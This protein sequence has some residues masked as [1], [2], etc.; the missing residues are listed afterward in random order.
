PFPEMG[1]EGAALATG[2]GQALSLV[3]YLA[4]Y[5]AKM[6]PIRLHFNREIADPA[7][8]KKMYAVGVPATFSLALPTLLITCLNIILAASSEVSGL[9]RGV[10]YKLQT[11]LY[12]PANGIVQGVR[13]L[14]GYNYGAKEP[15]RVRQIFL[16]G[17][18]LS[19]GIMVL[20][21]VLCW[22]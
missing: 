12:L 6:I 7:I 17:L 9:V 3:I 2:I 8:A 15:A 20:G 16:T 14:V 5:A 13:P 1:I 22:T 18:A 11:S 21:T 19:A 10:Y 4:C